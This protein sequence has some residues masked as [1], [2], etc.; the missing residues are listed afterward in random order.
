MILD[1]DRL[2][3]SFDKPE[4]IRSSPYD[5]KHCLNIQF[6]I[7]YRHHVMANKPFR[8][9]CVNGGGMLGIMPA[10][11]LEHLE[12]VTCQPLSQSFDLICGTSVGAVIAGVI[13]SPADI[14][15]SDA[16]NSLKNTKMFKSNFFRTLWTCGGIIR[17]RISTKRRD[18]ELQK[19]YGQTKLAECSPPILTVSFDVKGGTAKT[20]STRRTPDVAIGDAVKA[21]ASVPT[22]WKP[23]QVNDSICIDGGL[24]SNNPTLYGIIE[25]LTNYNIESRDI[26]IMSL[27]TGYLT[28]STSARVAGKLTGFR[29]IDTLVRTFASA[30]TVN[31]VN[32]TSQLV[33]NMNRFVHIDFPLTLSQFKFLSTKKKDVDALDRVS[34]QVIE[35]CDDVIRKFGDEL[36][37]KAQTL[38]YDRLQSSE[39]H[40]YFTNLPSGA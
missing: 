4:C 25:A 20:F 28:G 6:A 31:S 33:T 5:S 36:T 37:G 26:V 16:I 35:E 10:R 34:A 21:S 32:L 30:N 8:I 18:E 2:R 7:K 17:P 14:H 39:N 13:A 1:A 23:H 19:L 24:F 40:R 22:I 12:K 29:L 3:Q 9:L 11:V 15:I 38:A 27:G